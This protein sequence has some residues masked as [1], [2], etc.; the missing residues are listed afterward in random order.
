[1]ELKNVM[2][3]VVWHAINLLLPQMDCCKCEK[4][5]K[6][7]A[8]YALNRLPPKYVVSEAGELISKFDSTNGQSGLD[9]T[10]VVVKGVQLIAAHPNHEK[11]PE[12]T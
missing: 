12:T 11:D 7:I 9:V 5:R 6:D 2:E 10:T 4:C 1:M 8:A 3:E